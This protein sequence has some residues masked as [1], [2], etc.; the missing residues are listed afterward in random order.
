MRLDAISQ[1]NQAL[2]YMERYVDEG[3]KSYSPFA[4]R[5]EVAPEYQP[6]RGNPSFDLVTVSIFISFGTNRADRINAPADTLQDIE[7]KVQ[8][9]WF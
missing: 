5:S 4:A 9:C 7:K 6:R 8:R 2:L 3:A 1:G